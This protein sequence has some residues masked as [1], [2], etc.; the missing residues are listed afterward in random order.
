MTEHKYEEVYHLI[1]VTNN[2][3][4]VATFRTAQAARDYVNTTYA[5]HDIRWSGDW[6]A[7]VTYKVPNA[8]AAIDPTWPDH[9]VMV[10][11]TDRYEVKYGRLYD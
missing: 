7:N 2:H 10:E 4:I 6:W 8:A 1:E 9:R 11:R 5:E 3:R